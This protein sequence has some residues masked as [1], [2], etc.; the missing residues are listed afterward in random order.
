MGPIKTHDRKKGSRAHNPSVQKAEARG[1]IKLEAS[2][3]HV[4]RLSQKRRDRREGKGRQNCVR[5][6]EETGT[7]PTL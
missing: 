1:Y 5:C 7:L 2:L 3:G 4:G 6:N